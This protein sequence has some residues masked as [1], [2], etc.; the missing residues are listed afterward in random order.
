MA[1]PSCGRSEET[2][3][4]RAAWLRARLA[5]ATCLIVEPETPERHMTGDWRRGVLASQTQPSSA[6]RGMP[7]E[8]SVTVPS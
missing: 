3:R 5:K 8:S 2:I 1:V 6:E 7:A 4:E